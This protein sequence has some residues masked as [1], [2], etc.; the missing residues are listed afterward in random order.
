M[1]IITDHVL[2]LLEPITEELKVSPRLEISDREYN[3]FWRYH[4]HFPAEFA[5]AL[6][7]ALPDGHTFVQYD[8]LKNELITTH[9]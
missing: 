4:G 6:M 3:L 8:H 5:A 7:K 2:E 1:N 9:E